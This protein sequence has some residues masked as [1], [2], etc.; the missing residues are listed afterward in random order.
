MCHVL[1]IKCEM[2]RHGSCPPGSVQ[3][4]MG[5]KQENTTY[6]MRKVKSLCGEEVAFG[7]EQAERCGQREQQALW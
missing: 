1:V 5:F 7:L 6:M 4:S 2:N 3:S